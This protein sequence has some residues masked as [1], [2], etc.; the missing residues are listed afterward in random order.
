MSRLHRDTPIARCQRY[1][2]AKDD[3]EN[4]ARPCEIV[5]GVRIA[6]TPHIDRHAG[7]HAARYP[8]AYQ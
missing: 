7:G 1:T 8:L 3:L 2:S 4:G 5:R 6:L